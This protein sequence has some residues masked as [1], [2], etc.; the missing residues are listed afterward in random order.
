MQSC[1]GVRVEP[2]TVLLLQG[3]CAAPPNTLTL[4]LCPQFSSGYGNLEVYLLPY[5]DASE[6]DGK[7]LITEY[8]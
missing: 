2:Q 5:T 7:C 3:K 6:E 4:T 8:I 1:T